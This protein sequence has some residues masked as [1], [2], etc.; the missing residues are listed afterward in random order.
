MSLSRWFCGNLP[1]GL[2]STFE[3]TACPSSWDGS[4]TPRKSLRDQGTRSGPIP[5]EVSRFQ[6]GSQTP[7]KIQGELNR[8]SSLS[9]I[10]DMISHCFLVHKTHDILETLSAPGVHRAKAHCSPVHL[11][12]YPLRGRSQTSGSPGELV[13][14][15]LPPLLLPSEFLIH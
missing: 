4:F 14:N 12:G 3:P 9:K 11:C 1:P 8:D 2:I 5:C 6:G 13:K 15:R 7:E 10:V